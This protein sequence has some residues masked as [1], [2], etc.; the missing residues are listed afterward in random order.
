MQL[1]EWLPADHIDVV[2]CAQVARGILMAWAHQ[3]SPVDLSVEG[4]EAEAEIRAMKELPRLSL[5]GM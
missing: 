4:E 3:V 5:L 1:P 2:D